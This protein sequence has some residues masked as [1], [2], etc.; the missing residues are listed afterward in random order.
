MIK[1]KTLEVLL[2][3]VFTSGFSYLYLLQGLYHQQGNLLNKS[4]CYIGGYAAFPIT[5]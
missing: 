4:L 5:T 1:H 2:M 3:S